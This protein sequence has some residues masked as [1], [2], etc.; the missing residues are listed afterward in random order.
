MRGLPAAARHRRATAARFI[1]DSHELYVE[2]GLNARRPA[3]AR[4]AMQRLERSS[5]M[6][7]DA[8]VT[9]ND[10]LALRLGPTL[11][12]PRV[13][14]VRNCPP[15]GPLV[16][17]RPDRLRA[18]LDLAAGT[19]VAL[20][21][22]GFMPDRGLV[23]T[24]LAWRRPELAGVHLVLMGWGTLEASLRELAADPASG[25]RVHLLPPV[26]PESIAPVGRLG[27]CG[28]HA[29]PT[30]HPQRAPLHPQQALRMPGR[31]HARR[32]VRLPGGAASSSM[33][34]TGPSA[35]SVIRPIRRPS[36][37]PC[38]PSSTC[39]P[40]RRPRGALPPA[41][42]PTADTGRRESGRLLALY[43]DLVTGTRNGAPAGHVPGPRHGRVR[44][45]DEAAGSV[46]GRPR[47]PGADHRPRVARRSRR[48]DP[49]RWGGG[50]TRRRGCRVTPGERRP[51]PAAPAG[52]RSGAGRPGVAGHGGPGPRGASRR[53]WRGRV[54]RDG[55]PGPTRGP[56]PGWPR[57]ATA[58][59]RRPGHL[60]RVQQPGP[61]ATPGA[62]AVPAA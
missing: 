1:Y 39:P 34:R 60:C 24:I 38:G 25:G 45:A 62:G 26:P 56:A 54:P 10:D 18:A 27:R 20:Y 22:G 28:A 21:H 53:R 49:D 44:L 7:M 37:P 58:R 8:L 55:L 4:R 47:S 51:R 29:D 46:D 16:E 11:G 35:R 3:P 5:A 33:T 41:P 30:A 40:R 48:G 36:R 6:G 57:R 9:V 13:V 42:P 15:V 43:E 2:A 23:E 31:G 50:R 17:P 61:H 32:L 14:V 52:W 19:P 59:L 12:A